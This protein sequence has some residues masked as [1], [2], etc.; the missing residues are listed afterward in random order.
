MRKCARQKPIR[1]KS[2]SD[3]QRG[4]I[5]FLAVIT[6][7]I[8][9]SIG[10]AITTILIG[11]IRIIR[12]IGNSVVAFYAADTGIEKALLDRENPSDVGSP[13]SPLLLDNGAEY[14]VKALSPGDSYPSP[15]GKECDP[16]NDNACFYSFGTFR[17]VTRAIE[18]EY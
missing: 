1:E 17:G 9:L 14:W 10:L 6:T 5:I 12:G 2:N 3:K 4:V 8:L 11:E 7:A 13:S 16:N 18:V 15:G